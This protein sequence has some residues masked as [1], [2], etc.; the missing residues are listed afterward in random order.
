M[1]QVNDNKVDRS[2][3]FASTL[4]AILGAIA[5][6]FFDICIQSWAKDWKAGA[7][8]PIAFAFSA[9]FATAFLPLAD[10]PSFIREK[11]AMRLLIF[12]SV[13]MA[14]QAI[15]MTV[16]LAIWGEAP[17]VN[18]VYS[19]RG[20]WGVLI[21]WLLFRHLKDNSVSNRV[22]TMRLVGAI[23]IALAV[24]I[25]FFENVEPNPLR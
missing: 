7:L 14:I 21:P 18:I 12:G 17:Q 25:V 11:G 5:M 6:S 8:L 23:L 1:I 3:I 24:V 19:L 10:R 16:T 13:L 22:M 9:L 15:G 4:L 20:M 2:K